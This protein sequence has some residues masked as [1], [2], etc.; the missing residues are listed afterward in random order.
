VET[1]PFVD[2]RITWIA[3]AQPKM[4]IVHFCKKIL[5]GQVFWVH[6]PFTKCDNRFFSEEDRWIFILRQSLVGFRPIHRLDE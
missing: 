5:D 1:P 6:D 2:S 4:L 3:S